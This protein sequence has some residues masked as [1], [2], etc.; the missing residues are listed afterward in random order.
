[1]FL[2]LKVGYNK[3]VL[4]TGLIPMASSPQ[5]KIHV[6]SWKLILILFLLTIGIGAAGYLYYENQKTR[7]NQDKQ[8]D[9]AAIAKLKVSQIGNWRKERLGDA[10]MILSSPCIASWVE[11]L[12]KDRPPSGIR[13]E[14]LRWMA[15]LQRYYQ[16]KDLFLVDSKGRLRLS[17]VKGETVLASYDREAVLE[18]IRKKEVVLLDLHRNESSSEIHMDLIAPLLAGKASNLRPIGVLMLRIDPYQFLYPLIQSWPI[19]SST[20][21]TLLIRRD[22]NDVVFL[23]E[24]RHR[25]D[26]ALLYR[27]SINEP[28][29]PAAMAA[30]GKEGIVHGI[31]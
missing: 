23:N 16:Y 8:N 18:A 17:T 28:R 29:L 6:I 5:P 20:S 13:E 22:N 4:F 3:I 15:S 24:L 30:R 10:G 12:M 26:T 9:L 7:I 19:P 31:D 11:P 25:K 21:E 2:H 14:V 1:M 27:F